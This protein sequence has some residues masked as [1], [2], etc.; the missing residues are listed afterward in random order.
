M[1]RLAQLRAGPANGSLGTVQA[2]PEN[3]SPGAFGRNDLK[4]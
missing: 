3:G 4:E 2:G 1:V